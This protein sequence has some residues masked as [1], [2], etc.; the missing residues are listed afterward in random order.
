M[1][2]QG[3]V[4]PGKSEQHTPSDVRVALPLGVGWWVGLQKRDLILVDLTR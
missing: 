1:P 4:F 3:C 2:E